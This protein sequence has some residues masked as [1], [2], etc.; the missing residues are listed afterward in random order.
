M[1]VI[2]RMKLPTP[3]EVEATWLDRVRRWKASG[4][5]AREF[6]E[7]EGVTTSRLHG[8]ASRLRNAGHDVSVTSRAAVAGAVG[9]SSPASGAVVEI[10]VAGA[11]IRVGPEFDEVLL[12]RIVAALGGPR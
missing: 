11:V 1:R 10:A 2:G 8:W 4:K 9:E 6:G 3:A 12:R 5:T 7:L